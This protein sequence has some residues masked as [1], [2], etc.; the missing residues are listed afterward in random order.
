MLAEQLAGVGTLD[1]EL[2]GPF[3]LAIR[4]SVDS[5]SVFDLSTAMDRATDCFTYVFVQQRAL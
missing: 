5:L 4:F 2:L 1:I 3:A